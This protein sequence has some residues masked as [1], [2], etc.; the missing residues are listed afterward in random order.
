MNSDEFMEKVMRICERA[1]EEK[2]YDVYGFSLGYEKFSV[3]DGKN[4]ISVDFSE[5]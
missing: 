1:L 2:G 4:S 5:Q 3:S